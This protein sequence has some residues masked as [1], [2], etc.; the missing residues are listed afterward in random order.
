MKHMKTKKKKKFNFF[1]QLKYKRGNCDKCKHN[2]KKKTTNKLELD[3]IFLYIVFIHTK[4]K[5]KTTFFHTAY[6]LN[7][8]IFKLP[9]FQSSLTTR[10]G[11]SVRKVAAKKLPLH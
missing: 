7:R 5:N 2:A 3:L 8:E 1:R 9:N 4:S 11:H 10:P 6:K